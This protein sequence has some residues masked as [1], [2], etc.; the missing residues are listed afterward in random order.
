MSPL[1]HKLGELLVGEFN[2][3]KRV[4]KGITSL[5]TELALIHATL[6]KVAEVPPDQ[7]DMDVK[8][9]AGKVRDLS[10]D[11]E[12]AADS[13][14][15]RVEERSDGEQPTNMKNKVKNFLKKTTKLF[16]KGK[17]LHQISDAIEEARDLAKELTD[18]R[19]RYKLEMHSTGVRANIDPRLLDMYKDVTEIVG[20]E[21]G[22][23]KLVQRLTAGDEGSDHQVKTISIVGFGGLGKTTL[24]KAVYDRIKVNFDCGAF[25]SVSRSP[26][27]KKVFKD[28]LYQLDK[29]KFQNIHTTTRDEKLLID[30]LHEFLNDKRYLIVIDDIWDQ[31]TWGVIKCALSRNGLGSRIIT[32]TRNINVS[33]ACCSSDADT[34]HRMKPLSDKES[35]MLFYKRIFHSETGCPHELQEISKGILKKCGG[36]PLAIITVASLLSSDEQ[37]KSKDHWCNLMN[38]IGHGLTEGAL[39]EDMK[40]ILSFSYYDLPSHLKTC[41]LYLSI[42]PEDYEIERERLIWRWIAEGFIQ[43]RERE[44]SLFEIGE[45]Y[46][47]EL[48]N[49]S[50]IQPVHINCEDKARACRVHDMVL[51][52][53][54]SFSSEENFVTIWEAKGRRSIHDSLRK[55]RRL[56]LQNTSMAE[57]SNPELG[58]TNM[59]QVRSF[60]LFMNEDVNPMPSLSPFQ[61]LR[62][63]DLEGCYLFGKQD[64]INLRH[65]GSLIHLR[66][67]GL[68]GTR[69]GEHQMEVGRLH[70][71]QTLDIRCTYMEELSPSVFRL[72]QLVRLCIDSCTKVLVGLGNLVS[73]EELGTMDVRHF[74]DDDFKELGN[75]TELRV[76]SISFSEEQ[77]EEKHKA[78][79]DSIGNMHK[80]QSLEFAGTTGR[81]DFIPGAWVPP[82]GLCKFTTGSK[83]FSTLPKWINP[84]SLPFLS[85]LWIRMDQVRGEHIQ[86][87]GTLRAL[88]FLCI[89]IKSD[90]LME[91]RAAIE[92]GFMVTAYPRLRECRF[93]GFV[94]VPCMFPRGA[95]PMLRLLE[96]WLRTLDIGSDLG[97]GHLP[98][99]E[100]VSVGLVCKEASVEEVTKGETA[101]RLAAQEHPN[102]PTL[103]ITRH[104]LEPLVEEELQRMNGTNE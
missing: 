75:L 16:G 74:S 83:R 98:S 51:D 70:F 90:G 46:F 57:L 85:Y 41:L 38:S 101:V 55:V 84:S 17:A 58:T 3:E 60:S 92:R 4:R 63:L 67:L 47:N 30:E 96:L 88:R 42:F 32:T 9:W 93:L 23:D 73:L 76:L 7:L 50:M 18:L 40:R 62:V 69:V 12:D 36:V 61:V 59:S 35:Q 10:Y 8:V 104:D 39:V 13:F 103:H 22:R 87:L 97:M 102:R 53:I 52:L 1:L 28:I 26:D 49:R 34:V 15:V 24:A 11:M 82:P 54:C 66:Y 21:E 27:I 43:Y 64:K 72:R 79:A 44:K 65:L 99:L 6:L 14:M 2:L 5:E 25:V 89:Q 80:L 68:K 33:E 77:N 86:I 100:Q 94:S 81:I 20:I 45:S 29:D 95:M 78:L 56:S 91:E 31:K 37:I 71:L 19:K 48:V